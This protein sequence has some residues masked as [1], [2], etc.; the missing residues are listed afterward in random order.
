MGA[1]LVTLLYLAS[2]NQPE[3]T[4]EAVG[5]ARLIVHPTPENI[6]EVTDLAFVIESHAR[7]P[8]LDSA[9]WDSATVGALEGEE[10]ELFSHIVGNAL[11]DGAVFVLDQEAG[12]IRAF[13]VE[14]KFLGVKAAPGEGP[15]ELRD[16]GRFMRSIHY[17]PTSRVLRI[18]GGNML[19]QLRYEESGTMSSGQDV[20]VP[21]HARGICFIKDR[22]F[23]HGYDPGGGDGSIHELSAEGNVVQSFGAVYESPN[24]FIRGLITRWG[25]LAC[26]AKHGILAQISTSIPVMSA[27][28]A[29][30]DLVW[31]V[32]FADIDPQ[33][34][35]ER[36]D[37]EGPGWSFRP[38]QPGEHRLHSV[39]L[40]HSGDYFY[41]HY[42]TKSDADREP[43][44]GPLFRIEVQTG[45]GEYLG[46]VGG[47]DV[48]TPDLVVSRFNEPYGH[49]RIYRRKDV[50]A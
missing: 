17:E 30:G 24:E 20:V 10:Y 22:I 35:G 9:E 4:V 47:I 46:E 34:Q 48:L 31:R 38:L 50:P 23:V 7:K 11:V 6:P 19:M 45:K 39:L 49:L 32:R 5:S 21:V 41:A 28:T 40:D 42:V 29:H 8:F 2:C 43:T 36:W 25:Q 37:D 44:H 14:G 12:E 1:A 16:T 15:G 33:K 18:L 26:S 13:D 27:F 3:N